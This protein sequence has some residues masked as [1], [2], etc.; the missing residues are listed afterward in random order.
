MKLEQSDVNGISKQMTGYAHAGYV[1]MHLLEGGVQLRKEAV[2]WIMEL[3]S[4]ISR[5]MLV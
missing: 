3:I 2:R 4:L 1:N 5:G